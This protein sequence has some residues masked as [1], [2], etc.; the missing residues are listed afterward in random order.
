MKIE[1]VHKRRLSCRYRAAACF[2]VTKALRCSKQIWLQAVRLCE[3]YQGRSLS[4]NDA[5]AKT[6]HSLRFC[7]PRTSIYAKRT[8]I[9]SGVFQQAS[10]SNSRL[11]AR[12]R[13]GNQSIGR[14]LGR[15][16]P[17]TG[18]PESL[19]WSDHP[20]EAVS[21]DKWEK[22]DEDVWLI[23]GSNYKPFY[24]VDGQQRLT[25][26]VILIKC[27][28]DAVPDDAK[29]A[30]TPKAEHV[31]S[32]LF[33]QADV[34]KA[35]LFGYEKDNPSYEYLKTEILGQS[36]NARRAHKQFIRRTYGTH[37]TFQTEA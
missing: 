10:V 25:T 7:R 19:Y 14:F 26:A 30:F 5:L 22:W 35:Y 13:L 9:T 1:S 37:A 20:L 8:K 6:G 18:R 2:F 32:Y 16:S 29:L 21:K 11:P 12:L 3:Y 31:G 34:S 28:L 17:Y 4:Q 27:L 23:T 33:R 24:I 36:S 15:P